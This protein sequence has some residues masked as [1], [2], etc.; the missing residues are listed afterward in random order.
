MTEAG[1]KANTKGSATEEKKD[2]EAAVKPKRGSI[3][4][5]ILL[6]TLAIALAFLS[7]PFIASKSIIGNRIDLADCKVM[8]RDA[9]TNELVPTNETIEIHQVDYGVKFV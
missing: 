5:H 6:P 1:S 4:K 3:F 2:G 9:L 8:R 7:Q